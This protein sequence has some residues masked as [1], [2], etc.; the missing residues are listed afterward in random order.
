M[1]GSI[2]GVLRLGPGNPRR[3]ARMRVPAGIAA[4]MMAIAETARLRASADSAPSRP[5]EMKTAGGQPRVR[6][7][8]VSEASE[9][10]LSWQWAH[11]GAVSEGSRH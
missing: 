6:A 4:V 7:S 1:L 3:R 2:R 8:L 10:S 5:G 11:D 9:V